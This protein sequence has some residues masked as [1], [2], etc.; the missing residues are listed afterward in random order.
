[1]HSTTSSSGMI[2]FV[3]LLSIF[4]AALGFLGVEGISWLWVLSPLWIT[5]LSVPALYAII[6]LRV[7]YL[8][9]RSQRATK[10]CA[11]REGAAA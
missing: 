3:I 4:F 6:A 9:W 10:T 7:A 5:A 1:M 11:P 2:T 8:N